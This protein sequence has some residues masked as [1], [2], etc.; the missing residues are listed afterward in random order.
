MADVKIR[1]AAA[2]FVGLLLALSATA[3]S[4]P[5]Q[6]EGTVLSSADPATPFE[7][8]NQ[9]GRDVALSD[10]AGR[11]TVLTFLYTNCPDV[12]PIVTAQLRDAL[13]LLGDDAGEVAFA[14]VSVDPRRDTVA[15]ALAFSEKW[16]MTDSWD[17]LVADEETLSSV[18]KAYHLDPVVDDEAR[19]AHGEKQGQR[20]GV[21]ASREETARRSLV[22]HLAPVYIIDRQGRLRALFTLPFEP[23]SLVHDVRLLLD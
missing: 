8:T 5:A 13:E 21:K 22:I 3:C 19:D 4:S 20:A 11:V 18:W 6:F 2:L 14:A 16:R 15:E 23:E 12:C 9:F 1:W 17:F 7:L 10:Y